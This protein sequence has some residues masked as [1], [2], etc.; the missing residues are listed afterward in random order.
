M[1]GHFIADT[2]IFDPA[3]AS[4][5]QKLASRLMAFDGGNRSILTPAAGADEVVAL[6]LELPGS[7]GQPLR[8]LA[9]Y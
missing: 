4:L 2:W 1:G 5:G 8:I 9:N 6:V 3:I 7:S